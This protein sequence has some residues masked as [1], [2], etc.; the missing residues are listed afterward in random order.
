MNSSAP[1]A[2]PSP[3]SE[4]ET[5][6]FPPPFSLTGA[7]EGSGSSRQYVRSVS[8]HAASEI[9]NPSPSESSAS[10]GPPPPL[11]AMNSRRSRHVRVRTI[12]AQ[13]VMARR[14][15]PYNPSK[16]PTPLELRFMTQA[17]GHPSH[18]P[19]TLDNINKGKKYFQAAL[20]AM[21]DD[22]INKAY[23]S[24][25]A[26]REFLNALR[27]EQ[28]SRLAVSTAQLESVTSVMEGRGLDHIEDEGEFHRAAYADDLIALS[29]SNAQLNQPGLLSAYGV[30]SIDQDLDKQDS[31][32]DEQNELN[33]DMFPQLMSSNAGPSVPVLA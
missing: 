13:Q 23:A 27:E 24:R 26:Q 18:I 4:G 1:P 32:G 10:H 15:H 5:H 2:T 22:I 9:L 7:K 20:G 17:L 33:N 16:T 14:L 28:V 29:I 12:A 19:L 25:L 8:S 31:E 3:N 11:S 30:G 21:P 6:P